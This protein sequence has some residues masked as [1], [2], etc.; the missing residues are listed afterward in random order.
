MPKIAKKIAYAIFIL[1]LILE[2]GVSGVLFL[3][4]QRALAAHEISATEILHL[5]NLARQEQNL[6]SLKVNAQLTSAAYNKAAD[7]L[8]KGYFS[9]TSP[10]GKRFSDFIKETGYNYFLAG[11]NL[12][13]NFIDSQEVVAAWKKSPTHYAN[14]VNPAYQEIGLAVVEG[15]FDKQPTIVVVQEFGTQTTAGTSTINPQALVTNIGQPAP[16]GYLQDLLNLASQ[17]LLYLM[18]IT[19]ILVLALETKYYLKRIL[20]QI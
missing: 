2:I 6:P 7:I 8:S 16:T 19:L 1:L 17:Y 10:E 12:A 4:P 13:I 11:E 14:L 18:I 20:H 9:H 15:I 3:Y 5:T